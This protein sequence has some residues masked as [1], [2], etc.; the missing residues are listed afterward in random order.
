MKHLLLT[1]FLFFTLLT[2][3]FFCTHAQTLSER[4]NVS[5]TPSSNGFVQVLPQGYVAS[6]TAQKYPLLIWLGG[7]SQYGNGLSNDENGLKNLHKYIEPNGNNGGPSGTPNYIVDEGKFPASFTVNGETF[8]FIIISPQFYNQ[9]YSKSEIDNVLNYCIANYNVDVQRIYLTGISSGGGYTYEY[10][11][12]NPIYGRRLAAILPISS[13][14]DVQQWMANNIASANLPVWGAHND[15]DQVVSAATTRNWINGINGVANPPSP[16]AKITIFYTSSPD[17][18]NAWY[19]IYNPNFKENGIS[20]YEWL[21]QYKRTSTPG[22]LAV[23]GLNLSAQKSSGNK[24][25]LNWATATETNNKGFE[26]ERSQNGQQFIAIDF[27]KSN[28]LNNNGATYSATDA[29]PK[30]GKNFYRLKTISTIG[31]IAYSNI[32]AIDFSSIKKIQLYPN[33]VT[34]ILRITSDGNFVKANLKIWNI[35]SQLV[36]EVV[37]NN[38][39]NISI[40]VKDIPAG[41]YAAQIVNG[42]T[43]EKFTFIKQ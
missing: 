34:D 8:K 20:A 2:T 19:N 12:L 17:H 42:S 14:S 16:L 22:P 40:S 30:I 18:S 24:T 28:S 13:G 4:P 25:I 31:E 33:P 36:K 26:I 35:N 29:S 27:V 5:M 39:N 23:G 6:N 1:K 11:G 32:V 15:P 10:P 21:L 38:S 37:L 9:N 3:S 43:F 41:M 7:N